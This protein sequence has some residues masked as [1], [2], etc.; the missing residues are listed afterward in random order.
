MLENYWVALTKPLEQL[1]CCPVDPGSWVPGDVIENM[2]CC[3]KVG[4]D[5][6]VQQEFVEESIQR[7]S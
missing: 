7:R 2:I 6:L 5:I 4:I 3:E 1:W